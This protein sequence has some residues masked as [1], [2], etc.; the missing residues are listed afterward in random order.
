MALIKSIC[1]D[2][3]TAMQTDEYMTNSKKP[4]HD[5]WLDF[6]KSIYTFNFQLQQLGFE[7]IMVLGEPG[8]KLW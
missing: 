4:G 2:T 8:K 3:L 5:A 7:L 6:G 1:V